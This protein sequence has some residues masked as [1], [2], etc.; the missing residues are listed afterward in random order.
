MKSFCVANF[1]AENKWFACIQYAMSENRIRRSKADV[2]S[3]SE[4]KKQTAKISKLLT[5]NLAIGNW[6][7]SSRVGELIRTW[8]NSGHVFISHRLVEQ[9][10]R[11]KWVYIINVCIHNAN[12]WIMIFFS[13]SHHVQVFVYMFSGLYMSVCGSLRIH[14]FIHM[15]NGMMK[16]N[17]W[18]RIKE[19]QIKTTEAL[20]E[21][22]QHWTMR[23]RKKKQQ[24]QRRQ[25]RGRQ[26]RRWQHH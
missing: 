23:D 5:S 4:R 17:E 8:S 15:N 3:E 1:D 10:R 6:F 7:L 13:R 2:A 25:R 19:A 26:W 22:W 24:R 9:R 21:Q 11:R 20:C 18:E 16:W 12:T 14:I